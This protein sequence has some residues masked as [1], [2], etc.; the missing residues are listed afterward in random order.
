[1]KFLEVKNRTEESAEIYLYGDIVNSQWE[2]FT[3][4]DKC[5]SD[6]V[7]ALRAAE[8]V[9]RLDIYINSMGGSVF[10]GFAIYNMLMRNPAHKA[11]HVDPLAASIASVVA[12][13]GDEILMPENAYLMIHKP[14]YMLCGGYNAGRLEKMIGELNK[15]EESMLDIYGSRL[16]SEQ[17][18]EKIKAMLAN[19]TWLSA[20]EAEV[21]FGVTVTESVALA[22]CASNLAEK[23]EKVPKSLKQEE[24]DRLREEILQNNIKFQKNY[25]GVL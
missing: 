5:P 13:A 6:I 20:S 12:M 23:Y 17:D 1:M 15:Y 16:R 4:D 9:K 7:E 24:S 22:A 3:E 18:R 21:L 11:V 25:E 14:M 8:G 2:K 19:E 10:G